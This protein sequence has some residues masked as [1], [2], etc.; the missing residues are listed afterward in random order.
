MTEEI[1][2]RMKTFNDSKRNHSTIRDTES[3]PKLDFPQTIKSWK[4]KKKSL[5]RKVRAVKT[6]KLNKIIKNRVQSNSLHSY[7]HKG[8]LHIVVSK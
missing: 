3:L 7:Y 1:D 2:H 4:P 6:S 5:K 8:K